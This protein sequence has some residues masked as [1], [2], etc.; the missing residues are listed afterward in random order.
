MKVLSNI[1]SVRLHHH[2]PDIQTRPFSAQWKYD[3]IK[4]NGLKYELGVS[5]ESRGICWV[6][7]AFLYL[8][9]FTDVVIFRRYLKSKIVPNEH[10]VA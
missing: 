7:G 2:L 6:K 9:S 4:G 3:K 10:I 8:I 5:N 1:P